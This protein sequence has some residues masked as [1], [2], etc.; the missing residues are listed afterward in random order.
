MYVQCSPI[1]LT[2]VVILKKLFPESEAT[3]SLL[4]HLSWR[5]QTIMN[6]FAFYFSV[7]VKA[8]VYQLFR[9]CYLHTSTR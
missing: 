5:G 4:K 3:L 9:S 8:V 7:N 1:R 2:I 6:R